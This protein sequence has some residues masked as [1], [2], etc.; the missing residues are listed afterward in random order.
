VS[1]EY[2]QDQNETFVDRQQVP[3]LVE[4]RHVVLK[5]E[6][7]DERKKRLAVALSLHAQCNETG[8]KKN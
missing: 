1:V 2:Q 6:C 4:I 3:H 7:F 8:W 5:I